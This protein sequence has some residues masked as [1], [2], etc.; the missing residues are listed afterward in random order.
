[1]RFQRINH[2]IRRDAATDLQIAAAAEQALGRK[3]GPTVRACQAAVARH[4]KSAQY[5]RWLKNWENRDVELRLS[6]ETQKQRF[7]LVSSLIGTGS[8]D[9]LETVSKSIQARLLTLA[10]E[11]DDTELREAVAGRGW[12]ASALRLAQ[13]SAAARRQTDGEKAVQVAANS[14]LT[15][16][17]REA[18]MKEIFGIA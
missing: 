7:E 14:K 11:A 10:A 5:A 9:G 13:A 12:I 18:R 4:R 2:L 3:L 17:E 16:E 6:L 8:E 1:L 15:P